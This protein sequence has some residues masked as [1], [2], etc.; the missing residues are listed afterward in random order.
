MS[1]L[2]NHRALG[3]RLKTKDKI[4]LLK[5]IIF[6]LLSCYLFNKT[7][8]KERK[9]ISPY[10]CTYNLTPIQSSKST[11]PKS[12][13]IALNTTS[14][15]FLRRNYQRMA[16][17]IVFSSLNCGLEGNNHNENPYSK[18]MLWCSH[19]ELIIIRFDS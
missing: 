19:K 17:I 11:D 10:I 15:K 13:T 4:T 1:T 16:F 3:T 9:K 7:N 8:K 5:S 12:Q 18:N 6:F 2:W 14:P